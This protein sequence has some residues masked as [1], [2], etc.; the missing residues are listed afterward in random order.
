MDHCIAGKAA[1]QA[2]KMVDTQEAG[3]KHEQVGCQLTG[4]RRI[5]EGPLQ[6][7]F[8]ELWLLNHLICCPATQHKA[9]KVVPP[10]LVPSCT[11][12]ES[13]TYDFQLGSI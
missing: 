6:P 11:G 3:G 8:Q 1:G 4:N 2:F 5:E 10:A 9:F 12:F 7:Q 13:T